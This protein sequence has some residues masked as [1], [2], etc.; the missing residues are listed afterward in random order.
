VSERTTTLRAYHNRLSTVRHRDTLY[1]SHDAFWRGRSTRPK[2]YSAI[3]SAHMD[4]VQGR[5]SPETC[6]DIVK[7]VIK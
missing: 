7:G 3:F 2:G 5:I 4:R 1:L 6:D